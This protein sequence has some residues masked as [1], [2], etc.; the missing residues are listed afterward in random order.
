MNSELMRITRSLSSG[1]SESDRTLVVLHLSNASNFAGIL[2]QT[3]SKFIKALG[4]LFI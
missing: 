4:E 1:G 3:L 2:D